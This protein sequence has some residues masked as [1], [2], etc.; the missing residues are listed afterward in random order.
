MHTVTT[1]LLSRPTRTTW[2][3]LERTQPLPVID[4]AWRLYHELPEDPLVL[5]A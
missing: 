4:E 2:H 3:D 1:D 5:P